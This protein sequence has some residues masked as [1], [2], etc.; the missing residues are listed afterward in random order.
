MERLYRTFDLKLKAVKTDIRR[1]LYENFDWDERLISLI[2]ARGVGKTTILLQHIKENF[3]INNEILFVSL[4]DVFF[5]INTLIDLVEIFYAK[6]GKYLFIDEVHKYPNWS[7]EIKNIYD[8]YAEIKIVF[9]GSSILEIYKGE[10]DL[11]RRAINYELKGLSFREYLRIKHKISFD[12]IMLD[13]IITNHREICGEITKEIHPLKYFSKYL[14]GGYY[15]YFLEGEKYY[16]QKINNTLNLMLEIDLPS[17]LG[18]NYANVF[19]IKKLLYIL[20]ETSP[21]NPNITKLSSQIETNRATTLQ[22]L[23][24]LKRLDILH[25]LKSSGKGD[26][27]LTKPDKVY[28]ENPNLMYALASKTPNIGT[29][30]KSFFMN[31]LA[32]L[33]EVSTPKTGDFFIDE[34]YIFEVGGKNKSFEQIK[35][36]KNSYIAADDIET[37]YGNKIPLWLFGFLY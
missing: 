6:G 7:R 34:K 14:E 28:L 24:Y 12:K 22:F 11:S 21:N 18:L 4:D 33:H 27:I 15:P 19:K 8:T 35:N 3:K 20:S 30:R 32:N 23:S 1:S 29:V 16:H 9:T 25:L 10:A 36:S 37:G 13:D 26:G 2:G 5:T 31:Q 17:V